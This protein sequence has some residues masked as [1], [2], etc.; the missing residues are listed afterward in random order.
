[1]WPAW[2][3]ALWTLWRWRRHLSHRHIV[4]AAGRGGGGAGGQ[5]L[6]MGGSDRALML[7]L[8]GMAVLAAFAL[9][10]LQA[11][12]RGGDRLVLGVLLH[13][14][15]DHHLGHL[16]WRCRPACRPSRRPTSPSWRRASWPRFSAA[17]A[18]AGGGRHA[19]LAVA[20]ALAHRPPP[21]GAVEEPGAAGRRRGAVLAAADDAVAA[22]AGLRAQLPRRWSSASPRH[23][24]A[25]A[26]IAA[27]G[28]APATVAA[29]EYL[30]PLPGR[31]APRR[32]RTAAADY[33]VRV[34]PRARQLP[35][36]RRAGHCVA[37]ERAADR[38]RRGDR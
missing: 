28:L 35:R 23:V 10:T 14:V 7:G 30:G 34:E 16:R 24:P 12:H 2:P 31:R 21:R 27:P 25:D 32:A 9:P 38:P 15:R 6:A 19:G 22:A 13:A 1:M 18:G 5:H 36:R 3:L 29:L 17:R 37:R 8:P 4:G 20:G 33:A 26:C 11:Q